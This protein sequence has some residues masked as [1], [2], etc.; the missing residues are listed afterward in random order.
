[1][2]PQLSARRPAFPIKKPDRRTIAGSIRR[3]ARVL[4]EAGL[5]S[6]W[7]LRDCHGIRTPGSERQ[8]GTLAA[9]FR[10]ALHHSVTALSVKKA[11]M[12]W[13]A[14]DQLQVPVSS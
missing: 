14:V 12:G 6:A 8:N 1:M 4:R 5:M 9:L 7:I 11:L 3:A 10:L 13:R 2:S